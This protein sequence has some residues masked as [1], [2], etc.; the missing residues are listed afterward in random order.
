MSQATQTDHVGPIIFSNETAREQLLTGG[1]VVTFRT[2][3][4]TTGD[5]W[6][7]KSRLGRKEGDVT[8]RELERVDPS[9]CS[10]L[11]PHQQFSGFESAER[12]QEAIRDL[13][14]R[15]PQQGVLYHVLKQDH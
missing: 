3:E 2:S 7:R 6:W 9:D 5:T 13:H 4:R 14:G 12:W 11:D 15:L 10:D 8:V 1:E